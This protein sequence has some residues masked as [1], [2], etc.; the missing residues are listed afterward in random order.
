MKTILIP[1][2]YQPEAFDSVPALVNQ[3]QFEDINLVFLHMFKLSDSAT[4]LMMLS[5]RSR[6]FEKVSEGFY[7]RGNEL[8]EQYSQVNSIKIEFL[9]CSTL[10][11]FRNFLEE[12]QIDMI[13]ERDACSFSPIHKSSIDPMVLL[14]KS[15]LPV[16]KLNKNQRQTVNTI[17]EDEPQLSEVES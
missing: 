3:L 17:A 1:T 9:Y 13:L 7:R 15:S 11:M 8:R 12:Q 5:R 4:E 2:D 14:Q 10:S 16:L 6:E